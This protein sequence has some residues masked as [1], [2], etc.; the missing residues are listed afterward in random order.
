MRIDT[1]LD[2]GIRMRD[3]RTLLGISQVELARRVGASRSW[4]MQ[5]ER[6]NPGAEVGLV[7]RAM[8][9]LG[10]TLDVRAGSPEAPER[11]E[12]ELP[13]LDLAAILARARGA[14]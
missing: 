14:G 6:G 12:D 5:M 7:F 9:A 2:L 3:Q 8:H 10:L 13:P 4:V 1:P 11:D